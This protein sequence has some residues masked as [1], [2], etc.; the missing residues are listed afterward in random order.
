MNISGNDGDNQIE[1]GTDGTIIGNTGDRLKVINNGD[2]LSAESQGRVRIAENTVIFDAYF[3]NSDRASSFNSKTVGG[4]AITRNNSRSLMELTTGTSSGD[5]AVY[6]STYHHYVAG[7]TFIVGMTGVFG[8]TS[9]CVKRMGYFDDNDGIFLAY[10][11]TTLSFNIRTSVPGE[12]DQSVIAS[13]FN[14]NTFSFDPTKYYLWQIDFLWQGGG[15]VTLYVFDGKNRKKLHTFEHS[16]SGDVAYM[17]TP[18]LPIRFEI[19]N[20]GTTTAQQFD[21]SCVQLSTEGKNL[22][23]IQNRT[24][25]NVDAG[26]ANINTS[27]YKPLITIRLKSNYV[28]ALINLLETKVLATTNDDISFRL[29]KNGTLS[30][31]PTWASVGPESEVEFDVDASSVSGGVVLDEGFVAKNAGIPSNISDTF[32]V[33]QSDFDGNPDTLTLAAKSLTTSATVYGALTWSE[34]F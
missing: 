22:V 16:G 7:Q 9:N 11:G 28:R 34:V 14:E 25:S 20:T 33:I 18:N 32:E 13:N 27:S 26:G 29:I 19:L 1:G 15:P 3:V 8:N 31:S 2:E 30:G 23:G 17:K 4:G 21:M 5:R 6:Q 10:D 24:A 12:S